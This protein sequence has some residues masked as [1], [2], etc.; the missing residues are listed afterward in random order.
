MMFQF[1]EGMRNK[2]LP[3]TTK[4]FENIM[5]T[6]ETIKAYG[7]TILCKIPLKPFMQKIN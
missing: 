2:L 1:P 3:N 7:N 4:W 5:K 6:N